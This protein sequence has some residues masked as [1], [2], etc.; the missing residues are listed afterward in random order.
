MNVR[1]AVVFALAAFMGNAYAADKNETSKRE[2]LFSSQ[3]Q[4]WRVLDQ[5]QLVLWGPSSKDAYLVKLFAPVQD[6]RFTESL[7]FIDRDHNGMICGDGSDQ[8]AIPNSKV[9]SFPTIITS[10]RKV[11]DAEL[12]TLGEQYK[13][14][15]ISDKKAQ[16]LKDHDKQAH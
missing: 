5:Q 4:S 3:P 11:D 12:V 8:I 1:I 14:K 9:S 2:C 16:A 6:L 13:V 15:L 7:A 10:M